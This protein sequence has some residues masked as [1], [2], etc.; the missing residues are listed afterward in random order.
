MSEGALLMIL[1]LVMVGMTPCLSARV[2]L[3]DSDTDD[4]MIWRCSGDMARTYK[5]CQLKGPEDKGCYFLPHFAQYRPCF[6]ICDGA[7][8]NTMDDSRCE[9]ICVGKCCVKCNYKVLLLLGSAT[10][11]MLDQST[12]GFLTMV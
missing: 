6:P 1:W 3:L 2:E 4:I 8:A 12:K 11:I 7:V 10:S 5:E 9:S